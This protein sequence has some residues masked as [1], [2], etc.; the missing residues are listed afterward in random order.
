MSEIIKVG[1]ADM[2]ICKIPDKLTTLGL[3]S[4]VGV[5]I[6]DPDTRICGLI[7]IMLPDST[8]IKNNSN[9]S[10]FADTGIDLLI[11]QLEKMGI[12]KKNLKAK[13]AGGATM[14]VFSSASDFGSVGERNIKSVKETLQN[15]KDLA[16]L[17]KVLATINIEADIDTDLS[18]AKVGEFFTEES[19]PLF[20]QLELKSYLKKFENIAP[21]E[22]NIAYKNIF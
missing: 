4:C 9:I 20:K 22:E 16:D 14:F 1:M 5:A 17:S 7:H 10:K 3:G 15:N 8:K 19:Y 21:K 2:K 11:E 6:L 12:N 13:I 18:D